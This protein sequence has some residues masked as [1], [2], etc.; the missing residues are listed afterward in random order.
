MH[1]GR[2]NTINQVINHYIKGIIQS[3]NLAP[4]LKKGILLTSN[5]KT[6]LIAFLI[7]LNDSAFVFNRNFAYPK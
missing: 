6:D 7:T 2:F 4:E 5:E 3:A 1:D